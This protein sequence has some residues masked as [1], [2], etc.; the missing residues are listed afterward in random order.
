MLDLTGSYTLSKRKGALRGGPSL[1]AAKVRD[2]HARPEVVELVVFLD[3]GTAEGAEEGRVRL[4]LEVEVGSGRMRAAVRV[5]L[6]NVHDAQL[7]LDELEGLASVES[8][9][10]RVTLRGRSRVGDVELGGTIALDVGDRPAVVLDPASLPVDR[11]TLEFDLRG[12]HVVP[13][14]VLGTATLSALVPSSWRVAGIAPMGRRFTHGFA[15]YE[16]SVGASGMLGADLER[17]AQVA[18]TRAIPTAAKGRVVKLSEDCFALHLEGARANAMLQG[19]VGFP[20]KDYYCQV[21]L[22]GA[23]ALDAWNDRFAEL[24]TSIRPVVG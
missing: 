4:E 8:G 15:M 20:G 16:V 13:P 9:L 21:M 22:A 3:G 10:L 6:G 12:A 11:R 5:P 24:L 19:F 18:R 23:P 17:E 2:A 14:R 1:A 7:V